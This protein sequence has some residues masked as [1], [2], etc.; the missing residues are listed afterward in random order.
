MREHI[1]RARRLAAGDFPSD[2]YAHQLPKNRHSI[3]R[4]SY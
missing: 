3:M 2:T 4:Y 1:S